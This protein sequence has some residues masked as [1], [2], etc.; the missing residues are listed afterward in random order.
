MGGL[1]DF[2]PLP[3]D[4][5]LQIVA[6]PERMSLAAEGAVEEGPTPSLA[7]LADI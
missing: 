1:L 5:P 4:Q 6:P 2:L 3:V 7:E